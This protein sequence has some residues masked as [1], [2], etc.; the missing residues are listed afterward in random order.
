MYFK[1]GTCG[2]FT[3][4]QPWHLYQGETCL[5]NLTRHHHHQH[6]HCFRHNDH[7]YRQPLHITVTMTLLAPA[8]PKQPTSTTITVTTAA[9]A[10]ATT[11]GI[12]TTKPNHNILNA[13]RK[14]R[15]H[16]YEWPGNRHPTEISRRGCNAPSCVGTLSANRLI[17]PNTDGIFISARTGR[18]THTHTHTHM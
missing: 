13:N 14:I 10:A 2:F 6:H 3:P 4:S 16:T 17:K 11:T 5:K 15:V 12:N 7:R 18:S 9:A 1:K 8:L